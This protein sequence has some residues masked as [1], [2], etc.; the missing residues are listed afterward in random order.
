[1]K[2]YSLDFCQAYEARRNIW[3]PNC[4]V[5]PDIEQITA[6]TATEISTETPNPTQ[7]QS[8][9]VQ[10]PTLAQTVA[11][12]ASTVIYNST[13]LLIPPPS[14]CPKTNME[15]VYK[16]CFWLFCVPAGTFY[17]LSA[18]SAMVHQLLKVCCP[19]SC[20]KAKSAFKWG[21]R[22]FY[23]V[24]NKFMSCMIF[25]FSKKSS[26]TPENEMTERRGSE[27]EEL[28]FDR[29]SPQLALKSNVGSGGTVSS[30]SADYYKLA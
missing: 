28:L 27:N 29:S 11:I 12:L 26:A 23:G 30:F 22:A 20:F 18:L 7:T 8:E 16:W 9:S 15:L 1:M 13:G 10:T 2:L 21:G 24:A 17:A 3:L 5:R 19:T 6:P 25:I 14:P 4:P